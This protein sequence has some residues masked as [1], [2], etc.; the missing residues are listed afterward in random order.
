MHGH[1]AGGGAREETYGSLR[2]H[3]LLE[4]LRAAYPGV[5]L[6]ARLD[7]LG[8][9]PE[10]GLVERAVR[11]LVELACRA[12]PAPL[13]VEVETR[14]LDVQSADGDLPPG[15]WAEVIVRDP[16]TGGAHEARARIAGRL[17]ASA[18][19]EKRARVAISKSRAGTAV[20][21]LLPA[22]R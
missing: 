12:A 11:D 3:P 15:R 14:D 1:E 10:P 7:A 6:V 22:V 16:G 13:M 2:L 21:I 4:G 17:V 5:D 9:I 18:L 19:V 8:V 20:R